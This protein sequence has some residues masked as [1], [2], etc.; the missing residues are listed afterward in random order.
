MRIAHVTDY[1]LPRLGGI[2]MQV[3]DL[4]QRQRSA[5]HEVQL[6][7]TTPAV[8]DTGRP[9]V[10]DPA[11]VRRVAGGGVAPVRLGAALPTSAPPVRAVDAALT[12][13]R[14]FRPGEY[15]A[16][17]VHMS[18]WSP[19]ATSTAFAASRAGLPTVV[20]VHSLWS[21]YSAL[22]RMADLT[23]RWSHWPVV[24][25]AVSDAAARPI[26]RV[27]GPATPVAVLPNGIDPL[28]W[29]V[30]P[31]PRD[32]REV[33]VVSVMRLAP[34]KRP[35]R[36]L[37]MF[38]RVRELVADDVRIRLTVVGEGPERAS[39][40]RFV[41]RHDMG[42]WVTLPGRLTRAE[43]RRTFASADVYAAPADLESFGIAALEARCAGLPVVAKAHGGVSEFITDGRD[44]LLADTDTDMVHALATLVASSPVRTAM[45]LHNRRVLPAVTWHDVLRRS[46]TL[47]ARAAE[48]AV[49]PSPRRRSS[50]S[51][52]AA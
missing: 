38:R 3:H 22:L 37:R 12:G 52:A 20:T 47:Y 32:A 8:A 36:L 14:L 31:A 45:S 18:M 46:D 49:V 35:M 17:H 16:V 2:E 30:D 29:Q 48:V 50:A 44:G 21:G 24:W 23:I 34:R 4:A 13:W 11:W 19:L 5:G 40:E 6:L 39:L 33:H 25:S 43:I 26:R 9:T 10:R 41:R 7:T 42:G 51:E 27:M 15:D 1:Y 28:R